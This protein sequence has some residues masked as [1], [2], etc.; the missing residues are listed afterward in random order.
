MLILLLNG[1]MDRANRRWMGLTSHKM[2]VIDVTHGNLHYH[3][4]YEGIIVSRFGDWTKE[5]QWA[6]DIAKCESSRTTDI[7]KCESISMWVNFNVSQF[8]CESMW[9]NFNVS[10]F[11]SMWVNFNVSQFHCESIWVNVSQFQ[12]ESMW[13]NFNVSQFESMWVNFNVSQFQC[14]SIYVWPWVISSG[15]VGSQLK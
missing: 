13:V 5:K 4:L 15:W 9:V 8:Q 7:A 12:C 10:Q 14:E 2:S 1:F 11:E 3:L 6:T